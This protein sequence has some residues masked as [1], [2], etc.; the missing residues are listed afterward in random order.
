MKKIRGRFLL[1]LAVTLVSAILAL[2]S[3]PTVFQSFPEGLKKI[4][5]H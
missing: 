3:F 5:S 2:P 1:L 4:L